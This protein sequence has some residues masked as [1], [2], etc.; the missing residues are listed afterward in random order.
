MSIYRPISI[1][2]I[3]KGELVKIKYIY[4]IRKEKGE[5]EVGIPLVFIYLSSSFYLLD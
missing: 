2:I 5:R 3:N 4:M 1:T